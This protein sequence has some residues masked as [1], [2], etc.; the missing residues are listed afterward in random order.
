MSAFLTVYALSI[1]R[2]RFF[3]AAAQQAKSG[4]PW[5]FWLL[6]GITLI[7]LVWML[8]NRPREEEPEEKAKGTDGSGAVKTE[9]VSAFENDK[10]VDF[11]P[12]ANLPEEP[13]PAE[14]LDNN[15]TAFVGMSDEEFP[16]VETGNTD[17]FKADDLTLIEGIGPKISKLLNQADI[18]TFK[19]L[20]E[21]DADG[22]AVVLASAGI[23][24]TD[25]ST[26]PEQA[27]LAAAARW[28]DLKKLQESLK[29]GRKVS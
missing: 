4:I 9:H 15:P 14:K 2:I 5:W 6:M 16:T 17:F 22:L 10:E 29:G 20:S 24:M 12:Y 19:Q 11:G 1:L 23:F 21:R 28:D 3:A 8:F 13:Q 27:E 26:W 7:I 18:H 25:P